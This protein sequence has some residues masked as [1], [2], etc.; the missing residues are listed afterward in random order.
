MQVARET[1][2]ACYTEMVMEAERLKKL[3]GEAST[4]KA[5][6]GKVAPAAGATR[7]ITVTRA[8]KKG[9]ERTVGANV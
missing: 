6:E 2:K 7:T 5:A 9:F 4:L 8:A 1:V 3:L